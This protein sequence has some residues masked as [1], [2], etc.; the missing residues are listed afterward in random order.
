[1]KKNNKK[2]AGI[3]FWILCLFLGAQ[4]PGVAQDSEADN[5]RMMFGFTT[6]KMADQSRKLAVDFQARNRKD[7]KDK[8]AVV[9]APVEFYSVSEEDEIL[10]GTAST[11]NEGIATLIV[12][13]G[14][15]YLADEEGNMTLVARFEGTDALD[16]EEEELVVK[17]LHLEMDLVVED[18]IPMA[19]VYAYTMDSLGEKVPVEELDFI[20]SVEGMLSKLPLEE[21]FLEA[22]EYSFEMPT[23]IPGDPEGNIV[24]CAVVEDHEEFMNVTMKKSVNWGTYKQVNVEEKNKLW[25]DAAPVWMYIVLTILL[26]GVW[27]N[28]VYT[29]INLMRIR[30]LGKN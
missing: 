5:Y 30:K 18:S 1:M 8:I 4:T 28:Y 12:A 22:G 25:T 3:L 15:K 10:L 9:A 19:Y 29:V 26:V 17:D 13:P 16:P 6:T 23:D 2:I 14:Q 11:D 7:K 27:A 20:L 24:V 21:A